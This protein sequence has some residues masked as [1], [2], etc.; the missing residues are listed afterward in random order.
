VIGDHAGLSV[1]KELSESSFV[2]ADILGNGD[3]AQ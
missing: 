1:A 2:G 3:E